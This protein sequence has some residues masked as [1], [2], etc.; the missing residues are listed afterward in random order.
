MLALPG[1]MPAALGES[2]DHA[3]LG[4]NLALTGTAGAASSWP[5][6]FPAAQIVQAVV[7]EV[8]CLPATHVLHLYSTDAGN[9]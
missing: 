9:S 7:L 6:N 5:W 8:N 3:V 4:T 2:K 1:G